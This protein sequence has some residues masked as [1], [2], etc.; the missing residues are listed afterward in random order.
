[1]EQHQTHVQIEGAEVDD[2][3]RPQRLQLPQD[4][5]NVVILR[6]VELRLLQLRLH[7]HASH[8]PTG[9]GYF[10]S[11]LNWSPGGS[12]STISRKKGSNWVSPAYAV[13]AGRGTLLR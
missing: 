4:C 5:V 11:M 13:G 9:I 10:T 7:S 3:I 12:F 8:E 1:M 2:A 6:G